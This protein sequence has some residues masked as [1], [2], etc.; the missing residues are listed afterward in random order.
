[1]IHTACLLNNVYRWPLYMIQI[2]EGCTE[3]WS[4]SLWI[5]YIRLVLIVYV[6]M[7]LLKHKFDNNFSNATMKLQLIEV[8]IWL[9]VGLLSARVNMISVFFTDTICRGKSTTRRNQI[10]S[11]SITQAFWGRGLGSRWFLSKG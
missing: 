9:V 7:I 5:W 1:M 11:Y 10:F 3:N 8:G 6:I 2:E 4:M